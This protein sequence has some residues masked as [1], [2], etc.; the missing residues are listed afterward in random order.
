MSHE[1]CPRGHVVFRTG[2]A[3]NNK[4]YVILSGEVGIITPKKWEPT[5]PRGRSAPKV[6]NSILNTLKAR[7][8]SLQTAIQEHLATDGLSSINTLD[9]DDVDSSD[10]KRVT[11]SISS[12]QNLSLKQ[13]NETPKT[14]NLSSGIVKSRKAFMKVLTVQRFQNR[15]GGAKNKKAE[16][17]GDLIA[18]EMLDRQQAEEDFKILANRYGNLDSVLAKGA[19]FGD[20]CK[21]Y[22][23]FNG[24]LIVFV[25]FS[26]QS[27][28]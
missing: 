16:T 10:Q 1:E 25:L 6:N 24:L 18:L 20:L 28:G 3:A 12:M 27:A 11:T 19:G 17:E 21:N 7:N 9:I 22:S 14:E 23:R 2:D 5:D 26:V 13:L 15:L 4:F 8:P